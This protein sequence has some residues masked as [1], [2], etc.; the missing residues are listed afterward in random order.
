MNKA[1]ELLERG[2]S[3]WIDYIERDFISSGRLA[4]LIRRGVRGLTSNPTIFQKAIAT[5]TAYD[6]EIA[7]LAARG[8]STPQI[9][10]T[11][12]IADIRAAA[13]AFLPLFEE[14]GGADG[15]VSLEV[16]PGLA[17]D[18]S[19][20][21][22]EAQ[23]LAQAVMRPNLMVKIP[24]TAAG[25]TAITAVASAG[26]NVN[27]TLIFSP[28]QYHRVATAWFAG[29]EARVARGEPLLRC[30]SVASLFVSRLD[31]K[32]DPLL[33]EMGAGAWRGKIA[34]AN[35]AA[36]WS[37]YMALH[38]SPRWIKL[39]ES[40]AA[41]QRLLWA[42]TGTKDKRYA[43]TLYV[44]DLIGEGTVNTLPPATLEAWLDHGRTA[45]A[46]PAAAGPAADALAALRD[47]GIP[48][49]SVTADLQREGVDAFAASFNAL[50]QSIDDKKQRLL[51]QP[52]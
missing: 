2:Q 41:R 35:A 46:L 37:D 16:N 17:D 31:S 40:G 9:Y 10:E 51:A 38:A 13:D 28:H 50:L 52:Q 22:V 21:T 3:I 29:L 1:Q 36:A 30:A 20:T 23:R 47:L 11:L 18:A 12:A 32:L 39:A 4:E 33:A 44:D 43:D 26:I 48:I 25:I 5:G 34:L 8:L 27:A 24:A 19:G 49:G 45:A 7:A 15:Y 6:A 42:S 14:S